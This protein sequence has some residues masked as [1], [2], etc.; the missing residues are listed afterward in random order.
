MT[1]PPKRS[2]VT[3]LVVLPSVAVVIALGILQFRWSARI[4]E[5]T[6][7]RLA[8]SLQM[9]LMN[10]QKDFFR[11]FSD[12]TLILRAE[13]TGDTRS[14]LAQYSARF[15][16][17]RG[18][19]RYPELVSNLYILRP[20][21]TAERLNVLTRQFETDQWPASFVAIREDLNRKAASQQGIVGPTAGWLFDPEIPALFHPVRVDSRSKGWF[22]LQLNRA[23]IRTRV[24]PGLS[25]TYFQGTNGLDYLVAVVAPGSSE[26]VMY[27]SDAG[28]GNPEPSDTDGTIDIFG[29]IQD[30]TLHSPV[31]VFHAP[32]N[33]TG[34]STSAGISW[35]PL[36]RDV[37]E[38]QDWRLVV[39][40]RRGGALGAF[41]SE[42]RWRDLAIG[43]GVLLV[44][45][46]NMALLILTSHRA[47]RL[48]E[49]QINFV[50]AVSHELRTPL[51]VIISGA[52]NICNGVVESKQQMVQYGAVIATQARQLFGLVE[53]ILMFAAMRQNRQTY[54]LE[55][56]EVPKVIDVALASLAGLVQ[57]GNVQ[58]ERSL[59]PDLPLVNG[60]AAA[61]SQCLQNLIANALKYGK[62]GRWLGVRAIVS[63]DEVQISVSD[64]GDGIPPEELSRIFEPFYRSPAARAAQIHGTGLGLPLSRSIVEAM[65]GK[66]TVESRPRLG[67]TFTLHIPAA[68]NTAMIRAAV[69]D[70]TSAPFSVDIGC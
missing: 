66:L 1:L 12:I 15:A 63:E 2:A 22:A 29:R 11:Y 44:L 17:W 65:K 35:F 37:P 8:D 52:D 56:L 23:E 7:V 19:A 49:L 30:R 20:D 51:T 18:L 40:H 43:F 39:R 26:H 24:L 31:H 14:D 62:R 9:S 33:D 57:A 10:W 5:A 70:G 60:D 3:A 34:P 68:H 47:Q 36:L 27:S 55:P 59:D 13:D 54:T 41:V 69:K 46:I 53:R 6:A 64:R 50:T 45:V 16:E 38:D 42:M 21:G 61:L 28:F 48:A 58:V 25:Q 67:S 4:S 32:S